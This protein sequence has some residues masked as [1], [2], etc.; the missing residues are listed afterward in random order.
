MG[1]YSDLKVYKIAFAL[2]I[3]I[4]KQ[5]KT[6][7]VEEKWGMASQ[8]KRSSSSVCALIAECYNRRQ[9]EKYFLYKLHEAAGENAETQVWLDMAVCLRFVK[10]VE[11]SDLSN[12]NQD[13]A[14]LLQYMINNPQKFV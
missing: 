4:Y 10:Q 3:D 7:P 12:R 2:A 5:A 9:H 6:F 13:I 8:L 14:R 11:Y 1:R